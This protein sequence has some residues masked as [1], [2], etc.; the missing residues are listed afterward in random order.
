MKKV[1]IAV[2]ASVSFFAFAAAAMAG[3]GKVQ[4]DNAQ[5]DAYQNCVR[6]VPD[7]SN[8]CPFE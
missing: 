4:G 7:E 5:G 3:G 8:T 1:I 6:I 2:I